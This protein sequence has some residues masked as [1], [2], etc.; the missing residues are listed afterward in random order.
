MTSPASNDRCMASRAFDW[1]IHCPNLWLAKYQSNN[2]TNSAHPIQPVI[3]PAPV[4]RCRHP[5]RPPDSLSQRTSPAPPRVCFQL[6]ASSAHACLTRKQR[7][8]S[9]LDRGTLEQ[10][11]SNKV[12]R[13]GG[14]VRIRRE[15]LHQSPRLTGGSSPGW[16]P[17]GAGGPP[18]PGSAVS[19]SRI[20]SNSWS[21]LIM[22]PPGASRR[23]Q[24]ENAAVE[25][26]A[27]R[28]TRRTTFCHPAGKSS[29]D[30]RNPTSRVARG[31]KTSSAQ[32]KSRRSPSQSGHAVRA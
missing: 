16:S 14:S 32:A 25:R 30:G 19:S 5:A 21:L 4:A 3:A 7:P 9:I 24:P 18:V 28:S 17:P 11:V 31:C 13:V 12:E 26:G 29:G 20:A 15:H 6:K 8:A 1:R 23:C 27:A 10:G 22:A 2:R